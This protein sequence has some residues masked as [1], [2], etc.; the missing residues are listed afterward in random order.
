M[1]DLVGNPEDWFSHVVAHL[2][3]Q[4]KQ[5]EPANLKNGIFVPDCTKHF[6]HTCT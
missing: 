1:S 5:W 4:K 6:K 3:I 2:T